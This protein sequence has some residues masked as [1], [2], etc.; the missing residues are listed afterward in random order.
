MVNGGNYI[1]MEGG[2]SFSVFTTP[3][4]PITIQFEIGVAG[5]GG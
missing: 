4:L 2:P 5:E 3:N 1:E